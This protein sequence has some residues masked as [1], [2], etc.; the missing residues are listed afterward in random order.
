[1]SA[2][3]VGKLPNCVDHPLGAVLNLDDHLTGLACQLQALLGLSTAAGHVT[4]GF[5]GQLLVLLYH[6]NDLLGS[7]TGAP[8][9]L[10]NLVGNHRKAASLLTGARRFDG[11]VQGQ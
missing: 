3:L 6:R 7:R 2:Q 5:V 9:Q 11:S 1:M 8:G 4:H 10:P